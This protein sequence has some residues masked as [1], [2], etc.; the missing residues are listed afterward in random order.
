MRWCAAA[1]Q[2]YIPVYT[3]RFSNYLQ[4]YI[5]TPSSD[6][7]VTR[8]Y[9]SGAGLSSAT[10]LVPCAPCRSLPKRAARPGNGHAEFAAGPVLCVSRTERG[11][12]PC[13]PICRFIE[14]SKDFEDR[15]KALQ[16]YSRQPSS[17]DGDDT[18]PTAA[19][20]SFRNAAKALRDAI[21]QRSGRSPGHK[22]SDC[23][24]SDFV[25]EDPPEEVPDEELFPLMQS[26]W[27]EVGCLLRLQLNSSEALDDARS[28]VG[29][30]VSFDVTL[31][32][33]AQS[34]GVLKGTI[35][36]ALLAFADGRAESTAES[37]GVQLSDGDWAELSQGSDA[38]RKLVR[39][40]VQDDNDLKA[41]NLALKSCA[42]FFDNLKC[43]ASRHGMA[44]T[45]VLTKLDEAF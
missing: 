20:S 24:A 36:Q 31:A 27:V 8:V 34:S 40:K 29:A 33:R 18:V 4:L 11:S 9:S 10:S 5:S 35:F 3:R 17:H 42:D 43:Y 6:I 45:D 37:V 25:A 21:T 13:A 22:N 26:Q 14:I 28:R 39:I 19:A 12:P 30:S 41:A 23:K 15:R 16:D 1:V 7:N 2:L 44:E 32:E 38:L